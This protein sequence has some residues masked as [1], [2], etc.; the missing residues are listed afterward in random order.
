MNMGL[1]VDN[2]CIY[3]NFIRGPSERGKVDEKVLNGKGG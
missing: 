1:V 3:E 2:G